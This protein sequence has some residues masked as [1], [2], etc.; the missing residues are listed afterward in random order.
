LRKAKLDPRFTLGETDEY[1]RTIRAPFDD[2]ALKVE[3]LLSDLTEVPRVERLE[4]DAATVM[5]NHLVTKRAR[6]QQYRMRD[7]QNDWRLAGKRLEASG[8]TYQRLFAD[9]LEDR[10]KQAYRDDMALPQSVRA[11]RQMHAAFGSDHRTKGQKTRD[12]TRERV[13]Q[14]T[15]AKEIRYNEAVLERMRHDHSHKEKMVAK[16]YQDKMAV[17]AKGMQER[18]RWRSTYHDVRNKREAYEEEKT[19]LFLKREEDMRNKKRSD[20]YVASMRRELRD[21]RDVNRMMVENQRQRKAEYAKA[22]R[23]SQNMGQSQM[24]Q[25]WSASWSRLESPSGADGNRSKLIGFLESA[26]FPATPS[27]PSTAGSR[28]SPTSAKA[29]SPASRRGDTGG[30]PKLAQT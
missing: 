2:V 30:L 23:S 1:G 6:D 19:Q 27:K 26:A 11:F 5:N 14:M 7:I 15:F 9:R 12:E 3:A 10:E 29:G 8:T 13:D 22:L 16:F 4:Y 28:F 20:T 21:L 24:S 18:I 25:T 17:A